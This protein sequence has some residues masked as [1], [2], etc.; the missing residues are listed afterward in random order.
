MPRPQRKS[1]GKDKT[2]QPIIG[3]LEEFQQVHGPE[4][5]RIVQSPAF[6]AGLLLLNIRKIDSIATLT[7]EDIEKH[8]REIVSDLRGHVRLEND[9]MSLHTMKDFTLPSEEAE[10]YFSPTQVAEMEMVKERFRKE[11]E[12]SRYA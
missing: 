5:L 12:K 2:P 6:R 11:N 7:N 9:L 1:V 4:W 8:G 10:E 3:D